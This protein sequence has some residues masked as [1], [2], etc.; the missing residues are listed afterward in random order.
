MSNMAFYFIF[1]RKLYANCHWKK[2]VCAIL[3]ASYFPS[4]LRVFSIIHTRKNFQLNSFC[5]VLILMIF[6]SNCQTKFSP[7]FFLGSRRSIRLDF[8]PRTKMNK[9]VDFYVLAN[10]FLLP[11]C[12]LQ[13]NFVALKLRLL[14]WQRNELLFCHRLFLGYYCCFFRRNFQSTTFFGHYTS[15]CVCVFFSVPRRCV[16][17][18]FWNISQSELVGTYF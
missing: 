10:G 4:F 8:F 7:H 17:Q 11:L 13:R 2:Q 16:G 12:H 6:C 3:S 1:M 15:V 18:K 9:F 5:F 14:R